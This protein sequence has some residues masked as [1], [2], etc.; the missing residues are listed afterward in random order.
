MAAK[1][2]PAKS[3][4]K[5]PAKKAVVKAAK[6]PLVK[7]VKTASVKATVKTG[8]PVAK[9]IEKKVHKVEEDVVVTPPSK[10]VKVQTAEGWKRSMK[11]AHAKK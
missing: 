11:K 2:T 4:K 3:V 7:T 9:A 8:K 1:K 5:T 10:W 6:K